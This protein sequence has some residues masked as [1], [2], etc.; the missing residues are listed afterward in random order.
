LA[1]VG[2]VQSEIQK[3]TRKTDNLVK[4]PDLLLHLEVVQEGV[5]QMLHL[6]HLAVA[7]VD[8]HKPL[9]LQ[10]QTVLGFLEET[11]LALQE[12]VA[13]EPVVLAQME[14]AQQVELEELVNQAQSAEPWLFMELVVAE[15]VTMVSM[16]WAEMVVVA[17]ELAL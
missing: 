3:P 16:H 7:A 10:E 15:W 17:R 11:D 12:L 8:T 13:V 5:S 1:V 4:F 2:Q 14:M 6:E 9:V